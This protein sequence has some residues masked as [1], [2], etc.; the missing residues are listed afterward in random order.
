MTEKHPGE[1]EMIRLISGRRRKVRP[2]F[3]VQDI[4]DDCAVLQWPMARRTLVTTDLLVEDVHF[5]GGRFHPAVLGRKAF[6][7]NV[8]DIAA[9]GGEPL[10]C[11]LGLAWPPERPTEEFTALVDGFVEETERFGTVLAGGDLSR[12]D[13]LTIAV[14]VLGGVPDGEPLARS[15][16]RPG[17]L[18]LLIGR[19]GYS[20]LGLQAIKGDPQLD[21]RDVSDEREL[22]RKFSP[23]ALRDA[24]QAHLLPRIYL[25]EARWL[26]QH[27]LANAM[28]DV[29]DGLLADVGHLCEMSSLTAVIVA[30]KVPLPETA[31]DPGEALDCA[32]NGGEDYALA[33]SA[34][35]EQWATI[36]SS[37]P[38]ELARPVVIGRF[39]PGPP[40]VL[41]EDNG[42]ARASLPM[43]YDHFRGAH[44]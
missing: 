26:Q 39:E 30:E 17:D 8:S 40:R 12:S 22:G 42:E 44:R 27:G 32:L 4:G 9:M 7:V 16:A 3:L 14:T 41:I 13:R 6:R 25:A 2:G 33:I 29:S 21:L 23:G 19:L 15:G 35:P 36:S 10:A 38:A 5:L 18:L 11:F 1:F 28:V 43:G 20:R 37:Y 24:L 31:G 34:S